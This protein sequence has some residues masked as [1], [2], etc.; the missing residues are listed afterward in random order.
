MDAFAELLV[1]LIPAAIGLLAL[2]VGALMSKP[3]R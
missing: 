2:A 1:L 3:G